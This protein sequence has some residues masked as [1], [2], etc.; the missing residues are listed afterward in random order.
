[1]SAVYWG[2]AAAY[3]ALGEE[4]RA[5]EALR[6]AGLDSLPSDSGM[7]FGSYWANAEDGFRFTTPSIWRPEPGVHVA[8]GYDFGDFA[9]ITTSDGAVAI[10]PRTSAPRVPPPLPDIAPPPR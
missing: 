8:Q 9:F 1:M 3:G 2:F 6:N 4:D 10:H 7:L 5:A